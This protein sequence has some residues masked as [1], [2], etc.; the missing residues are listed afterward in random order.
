MDWFDLLTAVLAAAVA[1][2]ALYQALRPSP[3]LH[4]KA[5]DNDD[6]AHV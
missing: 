1:V 3:P 6:D 4:R 5:D 2:I